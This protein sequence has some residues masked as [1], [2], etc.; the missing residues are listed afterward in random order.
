M[1]MQQQRQQGV[2][3]PWQPVDRRA[4]AAAAGSAKRDQLLPPDLRTS[5][6]CL[7]RGVDLSS[8]K[9]I[10]SI[11]CLASRSVKQ[12]MQMQSAMRVAFIYSPMQPK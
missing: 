7:I 8:K 1:Y 3:V 2:R 12:I 9:R 5:I 4:Q 11:I 10:E 6:N